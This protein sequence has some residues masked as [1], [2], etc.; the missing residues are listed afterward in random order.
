[1]TQEAATNAAAGMLARQQRQRVVINSNPETRF[2]FL[3]IGEWGPGK[4]G[5]SHLA[6]AARTSEVRLQKMGAD[7]KAEVLEVTMPS[8]PMPIAYA[9]F[10]REAHTVYSNLPADIDIIEEKFFEDLNGMPIIAPN[11]TML[12]ALVARFKD[13]LADSIADGR[14]LIFVDGGTIV[15]QDVRFAKLENVAPGGKDGDGQERHVP[16]QY[17]P[18]NATMRHEIM[19]P[20]YSAK[21]HT[22]ISREA[23]ERWASQNESVKDPGEVGGVALRPD[24]WNK[25]AHLIDLDVQMRTFPGADGKIVRQALIPT[26][27]I[28][29]SL[30]G[31]TYLEPTFAKLYT[32]TFGVPLLLR[33]DIPEFLALEEKYRGNSEGITIA[34]S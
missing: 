4:M 10:D 5:K 12:A 2:P 29:A 8:K 25:T 13:F 11:E 24:G 18:A 31:K 20:L 33:A 17:G 23:G 28:K 15:W 14:E 6:L 7:F 19:R 1:M 27:A 26:T 32:L 3:H 9:N 22:I 16:R 34:W 21:A 30:L